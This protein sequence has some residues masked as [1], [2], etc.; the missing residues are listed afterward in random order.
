MCPIDTCRA[1][2]NLTKI[3]VLCTDNPNLTA[4]AHQTVDL[5]PPGPTR[6]GLAYP[7]RRGNFMPTFLAATALNEYFLTPSQPIINISTQFN[8]QYVPFW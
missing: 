2:T 5:I 3:C 7:F 8:T 4:Q 1:Y 6:F